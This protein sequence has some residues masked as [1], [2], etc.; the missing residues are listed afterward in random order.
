MEKT[1][2]YDVSPVMKSLDLL[3]KYFSFIIKA[4]GSLPVTFNYLYFF[5][6]IKI[7]IESSFSYSTT[8]A[9]VMLYTF[10]RNFTV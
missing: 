10:F 1:N 4:K 3:S 9:L 5:K 6:V 2:C 7:I 8:K